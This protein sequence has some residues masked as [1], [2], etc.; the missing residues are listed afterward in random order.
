LTIDLQDNTVT[1]YVYEG[2]D[3]YEL[4]DNAF[5]SVVK[6]INDHTTQQVLEGSIETLNWLVENH[7][8][9]NG[10]G[11]FIADRIAE[12]ESELNLLKENT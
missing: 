10:F 4:E 9:E 11:Y 2:I 3:P 1:G 12:L 5:P 7:D 8:A 6:A